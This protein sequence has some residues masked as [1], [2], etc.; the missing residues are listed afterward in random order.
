MRRHTA[1][2]RNE[3]APT[4]VLQNATYLNSALKQWSTGNIWLYEDRIVYVGSRMPEN[5]DGVE[6]TDVEGK[7][8]VPGYIEPHCHPFQLYN[9]QTLSQYALQRGTAT[10]LCDNFA[11][12]F[13]LSVTKALTLM[14]NMNELPA[15][16]FWWCRY[17]AQTELLE[18]EKYFSVTSIKKLLDSP[19]VLQGG[20]LTSWPRVLQGDDTILQWMKDT[21]RAG[22]RIEGHLPGASEKTLQQMV[23]LGVDCDHEAMTGAEAIDRLNAGLTLSLRYSSIRPDLPKLLRELK[24]EGV[25]NF[26]RIFMTT[27]GSTPG[28]YKDGVTDEMLRIAL[29]AGI[30]PLDAYQMA[31]YNVARYYQLDHLFGMVAPGRIAHLNILSDKNNPLPEAVLAKGEWVKK[32]GSAVKTERDQ[33]FDWEGHGIQKRDFDWELTMEDFR[34]SGLVGIE[35][36]NS[37]I[38]RPYN[39]SID[40]TVDIIHEDSDECF[41]MLVDR[42]GKWHI[43]T[44]V[45][46]FAKN[47]AGFAST[48]SNTGDILLIGKNKVEMKR[49]FDRAKE[50]GGGIVLTEDGAVVAEIKLPLAGGMSNSAVEELIVEEKTLTEE[51]RARGYVYED[52]IYSLL[53]FSSTHLPYIRITQRGIYD[54]KNKGLLFPSIMR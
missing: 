49:A 24:E 9:P 3:L 50:I 13:E 45:K 17:D 53:F 19:W 33:E 46:G 2:V 30:E 11:L 43:N 12:L 32:D 37:V 34:F 44:V 40:T 28:F 51:L 42:N 10:F 48:Y 20:E 1:V 6:I 41:L 27:D 35:M 52:P 4:K 54:V 18:E 39:V 31:S 8:V 7:F 25:T 23:L 26:D 14:E 21:K 36:Y 29:D 16:F 47:L 38:T 5:T 15:T 22:K